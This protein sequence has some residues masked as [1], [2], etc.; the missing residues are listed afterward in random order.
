[1]FKSIINWLNQPL[2][3]DDTGVVIGPYILK[4]ESDWQEL[5]SAGYTVEDLAN[6]RLV[7]VKEKVDPESGESFS[8]LTME[9]IP[10]HRVTGW[11]NMGNQFIVTGYLVP[12]P[13]MR[14]V[15]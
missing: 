3:K 5:Q 8:L 9:S 6:M 12:T 14:R 10:G 13:W 2:L 1:M 7:K 11:I 4:H 15:A